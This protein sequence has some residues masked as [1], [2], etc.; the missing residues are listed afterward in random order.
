MLAPLTL[1][2]FALTVFVSALL[3]FLVQPMTGKMITPLLGGTPAVWNTCMVFFQ[4][5]LLLGYAY[6]HALTT[7]LRPRKQTVVHL[8]LLLAPLAFFPLAVDRS[9]VQADRHPVT[10]VLLLLAGSVGVPFLVVSTSAPLLQKWFADAG[11][12]SG[13]DPYFLYAASNAGSMVALLGYPAVVEPWLTLADQRRFWCFAYGALVVLFAAC[14]GLV[15]HASRGRSERSAAPGR[16]PDSDERGPVTWPRRLRW[17]ALAAVP[18][19][20]TLGVTSYVSTDIAAVPLVWVV[21]LAIYLLS[22]ILVFARVRLVPHRLMVW[23]LPPLVLLLLFLS[24]TGPHKSGELGLLLANLAGLFVVAM[25][26]HGELAADRPSATRLTEYFFCLSVGGVVGGAFNALLAPVAFNS[27]AEYE[28]ALLAACFLCPARPHAVAPIPR[29][30]GRIP[31]V[32]LDFALPAALCL[33]AVAL[34]VGT[35]GATGMAG[36]VRLTLPSGQLPG[37]VRGALVVGLPT[38]ICWTFAGRPVRLGMGVA[39]LLLANWLSP[40]TDAGLAHVL[41]RRSFFGVLSVDAIPAVAPDGGSAALFELRHGTTAHGRQFRDGVDE[42]RDRRLRSEPLTYFHPTSPVGRVLAAHNT[43]ADQP[44]GIIGL[45]AGS[46]AAFALPGQRLDFYE[47]DPLVRDLA[48]GPGACFTF[49]ADARSRGVRVN[50]K[51]GDARLVMERQP[52]APAER[53]RV[54]VVDAF[55]SDAIPVHL[56][57]REAVRVYLARLREDGL[58]CFHISNRFLELGPVL[59]NVAAAEGLAGRVV[60][61]TDARAPGKLASEW[62]VL[63]R[64]PEH[65][66]DPPPGERSSDEV[67]DAV[68]ATEGPAA[69]RRSLPWEPLTPETNVGVWSD[70]YSDLLRV[71]KWAGRGNR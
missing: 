13:G 36:P 23:S 24:L 40:R 18:S 49:L 43:T 12:P 62:A 30:R 7:A 58:L 8:A 69:P 61:D 60:A 46:L 31:T 44:L 52:L 56:L 32:W 37:A 19:S 66:N 70:D 39:A 5:V 9:A 50:V 33:L 16:T 34:S 25:V 51:M 67:K 6:A 15:W 17:V 22:F 26:C 38:A 63:A 41:Q 64:R 20:L 47:I 35:A 11:H 4:F 29:A 53:Y 54:L 68:A 65:L 71:F 48:Q 55:S 10:T 2:T 57:T 1:L 59:A 21:P 27:I 14:A 45:G 3:L 42:A 28:L